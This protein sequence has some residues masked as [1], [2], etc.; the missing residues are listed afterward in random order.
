MLQQRLS[1][2]QGLSAR[3]DAV[4]SIANLRTDTVNGDHR[5]TLVNGVSLDVRAGETLAIVGE[6]GSGKTMTFMSAIGLL[7]PS[8]RVVSG[9]VHF[10]DENIVGLSNRDLRRLR[11]AG[12]GIIFQDPL[13]S[14]NPVFTIGQQL[15]EVIRAHHAISK[16]EARERAVDALRRVQIPSPQTRLDAYPHQ[17]SGGMRQ[18]VLIAMAVALSPKVLIADEPT[19]AL[20]V[21][22]QA[23]ILDL[24]AGLRDETG[25]GLVLIT[26]DLGLVAKYADRVAVMYAGTVV[27]R[28]LVDDIFAAP[29]H[30]YTRN[31][32]RSMPRLDRPVS[33]EL[34][35]IEGQPPAPAHERVG[36][37][38]EPR[39]D[40]GRG[41]E[42]CRGQT[43][44]L[45]TIGSTQLAA[46]HFPGAESAVTEGSSPP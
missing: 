33:E 11:G 35:A 46:C 39:C 27:E 32:L 15:V 2:V 5:A 43:P 26:H 20:D 25:M 16:R 36:C 17:L 21:T 24:L 12:I 31:L 42:V 10:N 30:P 1:S 41:I 4:L 18:R 14:L 22:V 28:G 34:F 23:Q 9:E 40:R 29:A 8:C 45:R 19:T 37:P 7:P 6:S 44:V 38:F 13:T 3:G